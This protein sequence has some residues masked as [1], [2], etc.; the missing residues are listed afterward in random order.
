M[1]VTLPI[2]KKEIINGEI[3]KE[4]SY[5]EFDI[6]VTLASQIRKEIP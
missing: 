6:D 5:M 2:Q 3:K 1:K 4:K